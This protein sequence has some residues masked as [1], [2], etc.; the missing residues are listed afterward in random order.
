MVPEK[1]FI[2]SVLDSFWIH[3]GSINKG[4]ISQ[5][6]YRFKCNCAIKNEIKCITI[7]LY[8]ETENTNSVLC[9]I[10]VMVM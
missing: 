4:P 1:P 10:S 9:K 6:L 3:T 8:M 7:P 5:N 2:I